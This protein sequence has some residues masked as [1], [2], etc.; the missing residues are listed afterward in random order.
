MPAVNWWDEAF[1]SAGFPP[2][3]FHAELQPEEVDL[4]DF[5]R[6][7]NSVQWVHRDHRSWSV[8]SSVYDPR[9]GEIIKGHVRL[10]SLRGRQDALIGAAPQP[11]T[12]H[13]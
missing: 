3:T 7:F 8:G 6:T 9:T 12:S 4:F 13:L 11:P 2:G 10:G 1:Q 5:D